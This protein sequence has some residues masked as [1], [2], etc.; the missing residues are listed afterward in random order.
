MSR[1]SERVYRT[2]TE[3]IIDIYVVTI[4]NMTIQELSEEGIPTRS[5][6]AL[7]KYISACNEVIQASSKAESYEMI[8]NRLHQKYNKVFVQDICSKS[9]F[10][11]K[12]AACFLPNEFS[13]ALDLG[14]AHELCRQ[15]F[16]RVVKHAGELCTPHIRSIMGGSTTPNSETYIGICRSMYIFLDTIQTESV[17]RLSGGTL[18]R[19]EEKIDSATIESLKS[20]L[21][22]ALRDKYA[23]KRK[24]AELELQVENMR[25]TTITLERQLQNNLVT[26][27]PVSAVLQK[28]EKRYSPTKIPEEPLSKKRVSD[29]E[30][31]SEESSDDSC[32]EFDLTIDEN[33]KP[34]TK[35]ATKY[36]IIEDIDEI[37]I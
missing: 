31:S 34:K 14:S 19:G 23:F 37:Q 3:G 24:I 2:I 17:K 6:D 5:N 7:Q 4:R 21:E 26:P 1:S 20:E 35:P 11:N 22:N 30:S 16:I 28:S 8:L 27:A 33:P 13:N 25:R 29:E 10:V 32:P 18:K 12:V 36:S 15:W 9:Q